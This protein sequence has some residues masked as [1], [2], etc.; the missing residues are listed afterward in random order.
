MKAALFPHTDPPEAWAGPLQE[1]FTEVFVYRPD[2]RPPGGKAAAFSWILSPE[3]DS[4]QIEAEVRAWRSWAAL[5]SGGT[6][7]AA[8]RR[9][10][11][12]EGDGAEEP[13]ALAARI[14]G[15]GPRPAGGGGH[16]L[17]RARVLLL[18]AEQADRDRREAARILA[19]GEAQWRRLVA[20]I[21]GDP[22]PPAEPPAGDPGE[23]AAEQAAAR[24]ASWA[25]LYLARPAA[26]TVLVT[27]S[28]AA[29]ALLE[30]RLAGL[31][32]RPAL[33]PPA[34]SEGPRSGLRELLERVAEGRVPLSPPPAWRP[35]AAAF[36]AEPPR[37]LAFP[38][39]SPLQLMEAL[40]D[41]RRPPAP[42]EAAATPERGVT[43]VLGLSF[44]PP[45]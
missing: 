44:P 40:L 21:S 23:E 39:V 4:G 28:A 45:F 22:S 43:I 26:A 19:R 36:G 13:G 9:A 12:D 17:R 18:L 24:L 6:G 3:E 31:A 8:A 10:L 15:T 38:G 27:A 41:P 5:H 14:R 16:A 33:K 11:G 1:L 29:F 37:L 2:H 25:R 32:R 20:A 34:L 42:E 7:L 30:E 35:A